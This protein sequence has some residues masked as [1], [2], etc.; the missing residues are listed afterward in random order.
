MH[1]SNYLPGY[2]LNVCK[3]YCRFCVLLCVMTVIIVSGIGGFA[4]GGLQ[5]ADAATVNVHH[6]QKRSL[7]NGCEDDGKTDY[8]GAIDCIVDSKKFDCNLTPEKAPCAYEDAQRPEDYP[9]DFVAIHD[10][11]GTASEAI[12]TF[13]NAKNKVSIHYLV[14]TDGTVYQLLHEKDIAY[15]VGNYWYN[16]RAIGIEHVGYAATG[17]QSYNAAQY[18]ASAQLTAYLLEKYAIPL[19]HAH[20]VGHGTV[21]S[22]TLALSPNHVDPG[23]YWLWD[24]YFSLIHDQGVPYALVAD[25]PEIITLHPPTADVIPIGVNGLES[26]FNYNFFP[27]YT[28]PSTRSALIPM[29][30]GNSIL[31]E[32]GNIESDMSYVYTDRILD[33]AGSG[34]LMFQIWYGVADHLHDAHPSR[35]A[36]AQQVWLAVDNNSVGRG[37]GFSIRVQGLAKVYGKPD[38]QSMYQIGDAPANAVFV[39]LFSVTSDDG[40]LWYAI[41]Y[42]H[43][44]AWI[45]ESAVAQ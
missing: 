12:N 32:V 26:S 7:P 28:G 9:I 27:L 25:D 31:D 19:D 20:I 21:P 33:P 8:P 42:N 41:N 11:E 30:K 40:T 5:N 34:K 23:P 17:Y 22:P 4:T 45:P 38:L 6:Q 29:A 16:Q 3:N 18:L 44:Q 10:S 14:D 37:N 2:M 15:H 24:Y 13:H 35:F 43:R 36:N 39:S 1:L